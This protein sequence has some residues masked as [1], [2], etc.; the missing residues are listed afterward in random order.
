M[1]GAP[2][3]GICAE[4]ASLKT[5]LVKLSA[6]PPTPRASPN[7]S[8]LGASSQIARSPLYV[9]VKLMR[10]EIPAGLIALGKPDAT[11]EPVAPGQLLSGIET[12]PV[13]FNV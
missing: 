4:P 5:V 12:G 3:A 1:Y 13:L 9:C 7:K 2:V 8:P 10:T 6:L 11:I